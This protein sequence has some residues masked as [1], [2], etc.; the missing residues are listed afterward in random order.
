MLHNQLFWIFSRTPCFGE[1]LKEALKTD[2]NVEGAKE[3]KT[4]LE[5]IKPA[6]VSSIDR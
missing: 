6:A 1:Y 3:A 5:E 2:P 4:V